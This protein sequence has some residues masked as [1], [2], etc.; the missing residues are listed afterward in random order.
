M[1]TLSANPRADRI[2][3]LQATVSASRLNCFLSCRLKFFFRYVMQ[4][5]KAK[6][7]ALHVGAAVH[8]V[9][10]A[11]NKSRWKKEVLSLR[12]LHD[13]YGKAWDEEPVQWQPGEEDEEKK[14]G[15]RL[16]ETYMRE[17]KIP[18]DLRP[19]AVEV[20][21]EADLGAH[22]LPTLVGVIDLVQAG[23]IIDYKSSSQ[24]PNL[25]R[26][27]HVNEVQ[28]S[29]YAVLYREATGKTEKGIEVHTLVKLKTPKL[30]IS[31]AQPMTDQQQNRL[32]RIM[33]SYVNGLE[34]RDW[35]PS[36]GLQCSFCEFFNE[37]RG[38]TV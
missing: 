23:I 12:Q 10:K 7:A 36:P 19:D 30:V 27:F 15:W 18:S 38:W 3:T 34:Q 8:A 14:V 17:S 25:E 33:E 16:V 28:T 24:T 20:P 5:P 22:G 26:A 37:C 6:T 13:E 35:V 21:V 4:I 1:T 31:P 9:L 2:A 29:G 11:W 32:F